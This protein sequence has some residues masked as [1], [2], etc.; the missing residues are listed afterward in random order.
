[1]LGGISIIEV[2]PGTVIEH[3]GERFEVT[4]DTAVFKGSK[5]YLTPKQYTA[6]KNHTTAKQRA[7]E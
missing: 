1:M 6:L 5:V 2:E 4:D 3:D 7:A